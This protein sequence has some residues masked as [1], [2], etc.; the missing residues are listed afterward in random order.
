MKYVGTGLGSIRNIASSSCRECRR[1]EVLCFTKVL[2]PIRLTEDGVGDD[3]KRA[4]VQYME[5]TDAACS[6]DMA[7]GCL[8]LRWAKEDEV[9]NIVDI[10]HCFSAGNR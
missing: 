6:V 2:P 9:D 5:V 1:G 10:P 3:K 4:Y 7:F 8:C